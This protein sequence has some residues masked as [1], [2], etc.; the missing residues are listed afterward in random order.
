MNGFSWVTVITNEDCAKAPACYWRN[1]DLLLTVLIERHLGPCVEFDF[2]CFLCIVVLF[3]LF[4]AKSVIASKICEHVHK[5]KLLINDYNF[6]CLK[7]IPYWFRA[8]EHLRGCARGSL[9]GNVW[10]GLWSSTWRC[11]GMSKNIPAPSQQC[12][13]NWCSCRGMN[14]NSVWWTLSHPCC[15]PPCV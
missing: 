5:L 9:C 12:S 4:L 13:P 15:W 3:I 1:L 7:K 8:W 2:V 11:L 6:I 14:L 10:F